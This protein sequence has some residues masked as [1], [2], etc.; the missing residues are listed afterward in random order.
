MSPSALVFGQGCWGIPAVVGRVSSRVVIR[1]LTPLHEPERLPI[2]R[3][4]WASP[5]PLRC[6]LLSGELRWVVV[7]PPASGNSWLSLT[8]DPLPIA[9]AYEWAVLPQCGAVVLFSGTVRDHAFDEQG[10]L[11]DRVESLTYEAYE[12]QVVPRFEA[13]DVELRQRWPQTGRVVLIHRTGS[14]TLGESSVIA[15]VSASHRA[16]AFEAAHFAIDAL[17]LSAPIWKHEVWQDGADWGLAAGGPVDV[18]SVP[19]SSGRRNAS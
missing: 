10:V 13:I 6:C 15:V 16:E 7:Q 1:P 19:T 18:A 11:R 4:L 2:R 12:S 5:R 3:S 17:K 9:A 8:S 14:L